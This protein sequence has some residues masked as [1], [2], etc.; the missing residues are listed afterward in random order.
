MTYLYYKIPKMTVNINTITGDSFSVFIDLDNDCHQLIDKI[1]EYNKEY[2][3]YFMKLYDVKTE[4][5]IK[6]KE[7]L[8][9]GQNIFLVMSLP[10]IKMLHFCHNDDEYGIEIYITSNGC[11]ISNFFNKRFS[12]LYILSEEK[13]ID[14]QDD[15]EYDKKD[16]LNIEK[17]MYKKLEEDHNRYVQDYN[18]DKDNEGAEIAHLDYPD[19]Q[20]RFAI[21]ELMEKWKEFLSF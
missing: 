18:E 21:S 15:E 13:I 20:K 5:E 9:D 3:R 11:G 1:E 19:V 12:F 10:E 17:L 16:I 2:N 14:Y 8:A 4:T 7:K 6:I